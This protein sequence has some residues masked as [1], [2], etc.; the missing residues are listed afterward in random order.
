MYQNPAM[1]QA[2]MRGRVAELRGSPHTGTHER[3]ERRRRQPIALAR[4]K[5]GWLLVETGLR[6]AVSHRPMGTSDCKHAPV[7]GARTTMMLSDRIPIR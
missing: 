1:A 6:L 5:A 4:Q 2:L 7:P 3:R